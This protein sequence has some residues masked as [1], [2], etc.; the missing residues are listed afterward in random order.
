MLIA[1]RSSSSSHIRGDDTNEL[2]EIPMILLLTIPICL[3]PKCFRQGHQPDGRAGIREDTKHNRDVAPMSSKNEEGVNNAGLDSGRLKKVAGILVVIAHR[4]RHYR[5]SVSSTISS[6]ASSGRLRVKGLCLDQPRGQKML[7]A[8]WLL[9]TTIVP[10]RQTAQQPAHL[11]ALSPAAR[12][13]SR[14]SC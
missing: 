9:Q 13:W 4:P 10:V 7:R 3:I 8:F 1:H 12:S 11:D 6:L 2:A 5:L 14:R